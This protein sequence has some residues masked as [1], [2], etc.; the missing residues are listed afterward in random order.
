MHV[1]LQTAGSPFAADE[2]QHKTI[3][4]FGRHRQGNDG[5][6][7]SGDFT[8][9]MSH[10]TFSTPPCS[11]HCTAPMHQLSHV[12]GPFCP[13]PALP[14]HPPLPPFTPTGA[15]SLPGLC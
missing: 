9:S 12:D 13:S 6:A 14:P 3:A 8:G 7:H 4:A 2:E 15:L 11:C 5:A 1:L 10:A